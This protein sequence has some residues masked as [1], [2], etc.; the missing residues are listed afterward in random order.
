MTIRVRGASSI[1][2]D[3][4]PLYVIDGIPIEKGESMS[5]AFTG[6]GRDVSDP[7]SSINPNDIKSVEILKD[8]SATAIYG[9]K[10]ANGVVLITTKSGEEGKPKLTYSTTMGA[11][12][13]PQKELKLLDGVQFAEFMVLTAPL[14]GRYKAP[15]GTVKNYTDSTSYNW[16]DELMNTSFQQNHSLTVSGGSKNNTYSASL[17]YLSN[18]GVIK[19]FY[20][21]TNFRINLRS[22]ITPKLIFDARLLSSVSTQEGTATGGD[23]S[24]SSA[25]LVQQMLTFRP[26]NV[27]VFE[28]IDDETES[29]NPVFFIDN[30]IKN[31]K[32]YQ[33]SYNFSLQYKINNDLN[34]KTMYGGNYNFL[35]SKQYLPSAIASGFKVNGRNTSGYGLQ[36]KWILENTL[37]YSKKFA[38]VHSLNAM[39]GYIIEKG[40]SRTEVVE[41]ENI[42]DQSLGEESIIF[43]TNIKPVRNSY[44]IN[45]S[46]SYLGRVNYSLKNRY[47]FTASL[48]ADGSSKFTENDK[49]A[50]FPSGA[51]AWR[52]S[53]ENFMKKNKDITDFK[54]RVSYGASGNQAINPYSTFNQMG[55]ARYSYD[56]KTIDV[57]IALQNLGNERLLWET[58]NQYNAG[59]DLTL[60]NGR[61]GFVLDVYDKYTYNLLLNQRISY[62][63]GSEFVMQNVGSV[64]NRGIELSV[65]TLNIRNKRFTWETSFNIAANRNKVL[66][67][68][69]VESFF[70]DPGTVTNSFIVKEGESI[71]TM[72]GYEYTGVYHYADFVNFYNVN[73]ANGQMTMKPIEECA[74]IYQAN[75]TTLT[76]MPGVVARSGIN[77]QPGIA[78]YK[79]LNGDGIINDD[80]RKKIGR[81]D[82]LLFGGLTNKFNYKGFYLS[83]FLRYSIGN[84]IF[85]GS[86]SG[87]AVSVANRNKM[88]NVWMNT[89]KPLIENSGYPFMYDKDGNENIPSTLMVEDGTYL[90]LSDVSIGYNLPAKFSSKLGLREIGISLSA[91]NMYTFSRYSMYD[92]E[93]AGSN[94]LAIGWDRFNYPQ[95]R[96]VL[97][98][99][100][101]TL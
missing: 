75:R 8:A 42:T 29:T 10:G 89:W 95:S 93:I 2:A 47:L 49:F 5:T 85:N 61:L 56:N 26:V 77:Q 6:F 84:N 98:T 90:K 82:P 31:N 38:K 39:L 72:W 94:P 13:V 17:G 11:N 70:V 41:V 73:Q 21:R 58:T 37:N 32:R 71:G 76:L 53:E 74:Q 36:S 52:I 54:F 86:H 15:D 60:F 35:R 46:V 87:M 27:G 22:E 48:R 101:I 25:S 78:K 4:E 51:F 63:S 99:L 66:D 50:Y 16:Q 12:L 20:E 88:E 100:N 91:K 83:F 62:V 9:S 33:T 1:N 28:L 79:D 59:I 44:T 96:T 97:A 80:D 45:S 34:F 65:N 3:V 67:L 40:D 24:G 23:G 14:D 7:L 69:T 68:G 81:S 92:P 43:G 64:Q 19:S 55:A 18:E 30:F 57:G